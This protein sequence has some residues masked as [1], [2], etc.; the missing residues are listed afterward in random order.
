MIP[1][2][3]NQELITPKTNM[4]MKFVCSRIYST[5][6]MPDIRP[7]HAILTYGILTRKIIFISK[8]IYRNMVECAKNF[9][10]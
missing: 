5:I 2:T 8:W 7:I 10:K 1:E 3:F 9:G 4:W 6:D